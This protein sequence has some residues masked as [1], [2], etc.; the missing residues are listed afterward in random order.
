MT[1]PDELISA[2]KAASSVVLVTHVNPDGDGLGA[3]AALAEALQGLGKKVFLANHDA[4]PERYA[5]LKLDR[6]GKAP[7]PCDLGVVLDTSVKARVGE[8][9]KALD[10][11]AQTVVIDH[12]AGGE[13]FGSLNWVESGAASTGSMVAEVLKKL[14]VKFTPSMAVGLYTAL[15]FDTGCFRYSNTSAESF[16][17]AAELKLAGADTAEINRE[18]F[19]SRPAS[20]VKLGAR[21]LADLKMGSQGLSVM[22]CVS[23]AMMADCGAQAEDCDGI[24][25]AARSIQGVE[26]AA[27]LREEKGPVAR[28]KLSMRSKRWLDVNALAGLFGGGGHVRAAGATLNM[29][30]DEAREA[31]AAKIQEALARGRE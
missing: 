19:E 16:S 5:F 18:L 29:G 1:P 24:V 28:V 12:H 15:A 11:A 20:A 30:L 4:T 25:E 7:Q 27:M 3:E 13:P 8:G 21:A 22:T 31:V 23:A 6:W 9:S 26:V 10:A 2:L 17:L 14:G